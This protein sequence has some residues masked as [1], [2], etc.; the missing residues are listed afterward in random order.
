MF[1]D[2]L[3]LNKDILKRLF[4]SIDGNPEDDIVK[5]AYDIIKDEEE[6][7]HH[8]LSKQLRAI[9]DE[10]VQASKKL[11]KELK[12][13]FSGS[14]AKGIA[15]DFPLAVQIPREELRHHM[16]LSKEIESKFQRIEKE[17]VARTRLA[18]HGLKP[19]Q[20][21]LFFGPPG[22]GKS[23]GAERL[24]WNIGLPFYKVR[25]EAVISSY[26]GES[27]VNLKKLFDSIQSFPC[28][29]LLDEFD[30]IAKSRNYG[31]DVGEMH[32]LVNMVLFLLEEYN[33]PG[34][35]VATT[36]LETSLDKAVFRRFDEVIEITK[37]GD[38]EIESLLKMT[39]SSTALAKDIDF[40]KYAEK[41][42]GFSSAEIVK[43]AENLIKS[44]VIDGVKRIES[45]DFDRII[46][47]TI[48]FHENK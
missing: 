31:Q 16:V 10:N 7:G 20:K 14:N 21:I 34:L 30:I 27:L 47:E 18:K 36:N 41:L 22:C 38:K 32:R 28:V 26:L 39:F 43:I 2:S 48:R 23:M 17:F 40:S 37:P 9:L 12:D 4:K 13:I 6:K 24:A 15:K 46:N 11:G 8:V 19:K 33:A 5:V 44:T 42:Q 1:V 25:F 45:S 35:L 3:D 29:L